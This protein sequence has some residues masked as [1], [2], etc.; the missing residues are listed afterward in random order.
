MAQRYDY[1]KPPKV[2]KDESTTEVTRNR[3]CLDRQD[4]EIDMEKMAR[5]FVTTFDFIYGYQAS[6]VK[7]HI[8]KIEK[9]FKNDP[10]QFEETHTL[11]VIE[12]NELNIR[13]K[14]QP[15]KS[16]GQ[17]YEEHILRAT[18]YR[19]ELIGIRKKYNIHPTAEKDK[20]MSKRI[21]KAVEDNY[22][23]YYL[24]QKEIFF[25]EL[26]G[27]FEAKQDTHD[28]KLKNIK[29]ELEL[30]NSIAQLNEWMINY[31][32]DRNLIDKVMKLCPFMKYTKET[33]GI[34]LGISTVGD[35]AG[36]QI[37]SSFNLE[38][39]LR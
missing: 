30:E 21:N 31:N 29:E 1:G 2:K 3:F 19:N 27:V 35:N 6:R 24:H 38:E 39:L 32:I 26:H 15:K 22:N 13:N 37:M 23:C 20:P 25:K 28:S 9:I 7:K 10:I 36:K 16:F 14:V 4:V 8:G 33:G 18:D 11:A 34:S 5:D 17:R 12:Q